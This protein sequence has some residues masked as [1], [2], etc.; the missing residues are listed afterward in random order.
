MMSHPDRLPVRHQGPRPARRRVLR[1]REQEQGGLI[2]GRRRSGPVRPHGPSSSSRSRRPSPRA[3]RRAS[4][5]RARADR[6]SRRGRRPGDRR[7]PVRLRPPLVRGRVDRRDRPR[8]AARAGSR[9]RG[10]IEG[11]PRDGERVAV[12]PADP[13]E[14]CAECRAGRG[15]LCA[16]MRFAGQA[17]TDGALRTRIAWPASPVRADP[18]VDRGRRGA[19][20]RGAGRSRS[21]R[22]ISRGSRSTMVRRA[23]APCPAAGL[24]AGVYGAGP[25]GLVLIRALRAAGRPR[26]RRHGP[27]RRIAWRPR[28]RR[29]PRRRSGRRT[30]CRTRPPRSRSTSRSSAPAPTTRST[31][32]CGPSSPADECSCVGIPA[33]RPQRVPGVRRAAQG[34]RAAA[35]APDGGA[36]PRAGRRARGRGPR[37][38]RRAGQP[39]VRPR[40]RRRRVRE[41]AQQGG[42]E[43]RRRAWQGSAD[44]PHGRDARP[45]RSAVLEAADARV[46]VRPE[47]G[48]GSARSIV[49]GREL[50]VD[51]RPA[52]AHPLGQLSDGA[53]GGPGPARPVHV[54]RPPHTSCRSGCRP[55]RSTASCTTGRGGRVGPDAIG[56]ELDERWPFRGR[57]E[58]RFALDEDGLSMTL[59]ARGGRADAGVR[60]LA[61]VVPALAR[62]W[63]APTRLVRR[64]GDAR[65][66]RR[67]HAQRRARRRRPPGR[68]TTRSPASPSRPCSSGASEL[69]LEVS[70]T[71]RGGSCTRCPR[72]RCASSRRAGRLTRANVSADDRG[73]G[74]RR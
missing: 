4:A 12:D 21:T 50:L 25:I 15:R 9:A 39:P 52:G 36:G 37:L 27:A 45:A 68:G 57:A 63:R 62:G 40:G 41:L 11:G 71:C 2:A 24:R 33:R 28:R 53:V 34:A 56:I 47:E 30:A 42:A 22:S 44:G 74:L 5:R 64:R 48:G 14:A 29:E 20:A 26:D 31:R 61:P 70:S 60:R 66:R 35:R 1:R 10:V 46:V 43:D 17:P 16:A 72:T 54:R 73:A 55:T 49:G 69:R 6:R 3:A 38:A 13:C 65:P 7:R 59:V 23:G 58:Q 18:G 19:A 32:P 51:E 67:G 8:C